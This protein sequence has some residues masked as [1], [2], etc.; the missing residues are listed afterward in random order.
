MLDLFKSK[1]EKLQP[2]QPR[3]TMSNEQGTMTCFANDAYGYGQ[4]MGSEWNEVVTIPLAEVIDIS[5][6]LTPPLQ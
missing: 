1:M 3:S 6:F 5:N 2:Q 4:V